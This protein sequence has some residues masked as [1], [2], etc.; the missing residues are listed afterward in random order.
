MPPQMR[1]RSLFK[2][3]YLV[4]GLVATRHG[5]GQARLFQAVPGPSFQ[6]H[7]G[8][9]RGSRSRGG[10]VAEFDGHGEPVGGGVARAECCPPQVSVAAEPRCGAVCCRQVG[11]CVGGGTSPS[12]SDG[13]DE[14]QAAE[15]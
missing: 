14:V 3:Q 9:W 4:D 15:Q 8:D 2:R 11:C 5:V 12:R 13:T 6:R 7:P 10:E 1:S